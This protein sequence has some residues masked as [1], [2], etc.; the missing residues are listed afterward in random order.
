MLPVTPGS[1][2]TL[3]EGE[4]LQT[5]ASGSAQLRFGDHTTLD[6]SADSEFALTNTLPTGFLLWQSRGQITYQQLQAERSTSVR[7]LNTLIVLPSGKATISVDPTKRTIEI[8]DST[9]QLQF[10][11]IDTNNETQ[12]YNLEPSQT[13]T[14][15]DTSKEVLIE[16]N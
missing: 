14:I 10:A 6:V 16:N 11:F 12:L 1:P 5:D 9:E 15:D 2:L 3:I 7:A 13:A 8:T 4:A